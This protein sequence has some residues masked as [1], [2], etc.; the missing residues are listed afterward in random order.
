MAYYIKN[1]DFYLSSYATYAELAWTLDSRKARYYPSYRAARKDARNLDIVKRVE[2]LEVSAEEAMFEALSNKIALKLDHR[3]RLS[4][5]DY[6]YE[7]GLDT[8]TYRS[9]YFHSPATAN[10]CTVW[11]VTDKI[12]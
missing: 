6:M 4:L 8:T 7:N 9:G 10:Y 12:S 5:S 1:N 2:I 3:Q 11:L